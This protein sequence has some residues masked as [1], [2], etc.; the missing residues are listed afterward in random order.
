MASR[1]WFGPK[2]FGIGYGPRSW[3][4]WLLTAAYALV[5]VG[6]IVAI[7]ALFDAPPSPWKLVIPLSW[8]LAVTGLYS[9]IADR[10]T[11]GD[12]R[13]RWGRD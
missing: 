3:Q 13:W 6:G 4:G 11:E 8:L 10:H 1:A 12:L 7:Q 5:A 9:W 2:Q